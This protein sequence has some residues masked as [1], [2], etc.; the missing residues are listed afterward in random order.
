MNRARARVLSF[1]AVELEATHGHRLMAVVIDKAIEWKE[2]TMKARWL[3]ASW[4]YLTLLGVIALEV[5]FITFTVIFII[6]KF[7]R[8][9]R[10]GLIES[11]VVNH[12]VPPEKLASPARGN[13]ATAFDG[14][15]WD[16]AAAANQ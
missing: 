10:D 4:A 13:L 5:L 8:L 7:Q 16:Q 9:M 11:D 3:W 12:E 6:P 2:M 1:L 14:S 15:A